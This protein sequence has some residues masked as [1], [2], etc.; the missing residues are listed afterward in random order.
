VAAVSR[1]IM[2]IYTVV[3]KYYS[4]FLLTVCFVLFLTYD[5]RQQRS[6]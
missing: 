4:H 2:V 6:D 5:R 3:V 1:I